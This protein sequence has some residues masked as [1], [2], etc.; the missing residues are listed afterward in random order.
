MR[1]VETKLT[2]MIEEDRM[3]INSFSKNTMTN[4]S[5]YNFLGELQDIH[6]ISIDVESKR[7]TEEDLLERAPHPVR[8]TSKRKFAKI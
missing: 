8:T 5:S 6:T 1:E 4:C 3:N 7:Y 2:Q